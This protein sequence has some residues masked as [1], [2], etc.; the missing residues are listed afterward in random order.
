MTHSDFSI[1]SVKSSETVSKRF[2]QNSVSNIVCKDPATFIELFYAN[3]TVFNP[4]L[5][6]I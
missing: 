6:H 5:N 4:F 2:V 1:H 3:R